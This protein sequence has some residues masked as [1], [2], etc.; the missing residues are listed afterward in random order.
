MPSP[1]ENTGTL[2]AILMG[3]AQI[4][5]PLKDDLKDNKA[6][7]LL[8]QLGLELPDA[9][10]G[11]SGFANAAN[12]TFTA[13]S[14]LPDLVQEVVDG[15]D[16]GDYSKIGDL[17]QAIIT[18]V[19]AIKDLADAIKTLSGVSGI[20]QNELNEFAEKLPRRLF[21]YLVVRNLE[22]VPVLPEV[23]EFVGIIQ[24]E[25]QKIGSEGHGNAEINKYIFDINQIGKF[26]KSPQD[27]LKI[28]YRWGENTYGDSTL[29]NDLQSLLG[30]AGVPAVIDTAPNPDVLDVL[31]FEISPKT[32]V[33]PW[34][35]KIRMA[36]DVSIDTSGP[37]SDGGDWKLE[38]LAKSDLKASAEIIIH[39]DGNIDFDSSAGI[40]GE[41]GLR[42]TAGKADNTPFIIFG[43]AE[44]S[45]LEV[46]KFIVTGSAGLNFDLGSSASAA[47]KVL[48]EIKGGKLKVDMSQGDGFLTQILSGIKIDSDFEMGF[49]YDSKEGLFFTGS[50]TLE[51]QLPSHIDLGPIEIDAITISIG[52]GTDG[53]E[54]KIPVGLSANIKAEIGPIAASVEGIGLIGNINFPE[55]KTDN[56]LGPVDFDLEFKPPNGVGLS[57]DAGVVKGGGY[58]YFDFEREEYAGALE[59]VFAEWIALRAIGL[60]TT[61]MPDGSKGFSMILIITVEFGSGIQLGFGFTLL[62]VGGIIGVNRIVNVDPLTEGIKNGSIE[63]VMFPQDIIANAPRIISDLR[64]FFPTMEDTFLIGPMVK[65]GW[66]T[67]NLLSVSMGIIIEFPEANF[68]ILGI[69]KVVLPDEEADILRLQVNFMGRLEPN[70]KLLWFF[71]YLYDSRVLFITL[72][73]GMGLLVQWG[74]PANFVV[75]VGGF[76]PRY[77]PPPLP[78]GT[79]PRIAVNILNHSNAKVR[80]EG[81]FAV[82]SN[83]VQFGAKV[84]VYFGVSAFN[85]DGH[86]GFDALFQ[87]DPFFFSFGLSMSLSVKVFGVGLFSVGFSGLLEGPTPWHIEGKGKI[88]LLFFKIKVPFSKTWG[89][90]ENTKLDPIEVFPLLEKEL[91]AL[92]N[93]EAKLPS[94]SHVSVTL[95]QLGE[96]DSDQLVLHPVGKLLISQRKVPLNFKI[97]KVGNQKPTDTNKMFVDAQIQGGGPLGTSV[98]KEEFAIGQYKQLDDSKRLSSPGYEPLESG[99]EVAVEGDQL[100]TSMATK[101]VIRYET[102][103]IDNNFKKFIRRPFYLYF[104]IQFTLLFKLLFGHFIKGS[105]VAQATVSMQTKKRMQ[106]YDEKIEVKANEYS[107]AFNEDN[108]AV[109]PAVSFTSQAEADQ[110]MNDQIQNNPALASQ[111]HV[112]PNTELNIV[113]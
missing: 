8:A 34:A 12:K 31:A 58:L 3:L 84:E 59:L 73:G 35:L 21:D 24:R 29:L 19:K 105:A 82:T 33:Q 62:G 69:I 91:A 47:F 70:N 89:D 16:A 74:S 9:V 50:S 71:A 94:T 43:E 23:L 48:G 14:K 25:L 1:N 77:S 97:D 4:M 40:T 88:S 65:I 15:I 102:N 81:Y 67:P 30:K 72:E 56:N 107:V 101:R 113:A 66:G 60:I 7:V 108:T 76:H 18:T 86:L 13:A 98:V 45:R 41:Y 109:D 53:G 57:L 51:I 110:F 6:I 96:S 79:I 38:A 52:V 37:I 68:T 10:N 54:L 2:E 17:L 63:S 46:A 44:G 90:E 61:K 27:V 28:L 80:I 92:T 64:K 104:R 111:L 49:G 85:I 36:E 32:D 75:S 22:G 100:K 93:W 83:S 95:R 106:P 78:F 99:L 87:F 39:P 11:V 42:F 5:E 103:I 20:P 112:I 55:D 26:I